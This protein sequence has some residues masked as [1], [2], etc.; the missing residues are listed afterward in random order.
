[1]SAAGSS[2][3]RDQVTSAPLNKKHTAPILKSLPSRLCPR[4]TEP[5]KTKKQAT[6]SK[7]IPKQNRGPFIHV[8]GGTSTRCQ[9]GSRAALG[10]QGP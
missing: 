7:P 2:H 6:S 9:C 5:A 8:V 10:C 1:V 3:V 4:I